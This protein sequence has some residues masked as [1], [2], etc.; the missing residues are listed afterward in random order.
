MTQ[1]AIRIPAAGAIFWAEAMADWSAAA[2]GGSAAQR[3]IAGAPPS[4]RVT[5]TAALPSGL[6]AVTGSRGLVILRPA[7]SYNHIPAET[8]LAAPPAIAAFKVSGLAADLGGRYHPRRFSVTLPAATPSYVP[9]RPSLQG[10]RIGEAGA[11]VLNL[12]WQGGA[13][14]SWSILQFACTRNG[15]L[16]NFSGQADVHGDVIVPLTGL[17]PLPASQTNDGMTVT[18]LGDA[19]QS[20]LPAGDPD[21]LKPVKISFGGAFALQQTLAVTR[22]QIS[23]LTTLALPSVTLQAN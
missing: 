10:T 8:D 23:N 13:V 12:T 15:V 17:P 18:A 11:V 2:P 4:M 9:L 22:G 19:T 16:L 3:A 6:S 1:E 5:L 14:A 7:M 21:A 20:G